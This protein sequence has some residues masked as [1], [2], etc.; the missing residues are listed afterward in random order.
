MR[1]DTY[2]PTINL[3]YFSVVIAAT[4]LFKHPVILMISYTSSFIYSVKLNGVKSLIFNLVLVPLIVG[5]AFVY[6]SYNH[7]GV[8]VLRT[9][10]IDNSI[11]LES[12]IYGAVIGVVISSVI[13]WFSCV[14]AV[15]SSD[16][17]IYLFGRVSPK[18]SLFLSIVLRTVPRVKS[19]VKR[20]AIAQKTIG[21]G[22]GTGNA[23][24]R[25]INVI[26][27]ISITITW[28][29]ENFIESAIS[30]KSRGFTLKGRSA[31]SLYRFDYRDRSFV[32]AIFYCITVIIMGVLLDQMNILYNPEIIF[33]R[34][35][36]LSHVFY[37]VY[38][39]LC[40]FPLMLQVFGEF[41][42]EHLRKSNNYLPFEISGAD[43]IKNIAV[44]LK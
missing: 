15:F 39:F 44:K 28:M 18:L 27:I 33:N 5:Y 10:F 19:T 24:R 21:R 12:L 36:V 8:T 11:T 34:I 29:L 1:F 14:H 41:R 42:F 6:S 31:F 4:I 7:F 13:M 37:I 17:I 16:K 25:L 2:H 30:M 43:Q 32:I 35:T 9:N 23:F 20:I 26:R 3:I 38:A 40:V 22:I